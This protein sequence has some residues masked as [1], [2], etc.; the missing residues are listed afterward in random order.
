MMEEALFAGKVTERVAQMYLLA[1]AAGK[2]VAI[3]PEFVQSER[4]CSLYKYG[5]CADHA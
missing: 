2:P 4:D 1:Q 5:T 3:P